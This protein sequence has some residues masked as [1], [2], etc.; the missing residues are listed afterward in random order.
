MKCLLS[1]LCHINAQM[2]WTYPAES[3]KLLIHCLLVVSQI[4]I[5]L[6]SLH[7]TISL[8]SSE[9]LESTR[10]KAVFGEGSWWSQPQPPH[11][12]HKKV[13]LYILNT[14]DH[15]HHTM[16]PGRLLQPTSFQLKISTTDD[17]D[18]PLKDQ[19]I[20]CRSTKVLLL[21]FFYL[22]SW[23]WWHLF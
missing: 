12:H 13:R 7:D 15:C 18:R 14:R 19:N 10:K 3:E 20:L 17:T 16:Q 2:Q 8:P 4:L 21:L 5:V 11:P 6:S 23:V 9:N 1:K 22:N